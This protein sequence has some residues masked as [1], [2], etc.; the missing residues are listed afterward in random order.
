MPG[1]GRA[2]GLR[3]DRQPRSGDD[4]PVGSDK[5]ASGRRH[6]GSRVHRGHRPVVG[7]HGQVRLQVCQPRGPVE[8]PH[9]PDRLGAYA[10]AAEPGDQDVGGRL[11]VRRS[12]EAGGDDPGAGGLPRPLHEQSPGGGPGQDHPDPRQGPESGQSTARDGLA[13]PA[14]G[15]GMLDDTPIEPGIPVPDGGVPV[16]VSPGSREWLR[17]SPRAGR[18]FWL[19]LAAAGALLV[20]GAYWAGTHATSPAA[21][22]NRYKPAPRTVLTATVVLRR[23]SQTLIVRGV[24][25]AA[26][27]RGVGFG[28]VNVPGAQPIVTAR[29]PRVGSV[30]ADGS[31]LAQVAGR[32]VFAMRGV[33]PMYRDL[34]IGD[35][36]PDV[37]QLQDGLAAVRAFYRN[38]G[39]APPA[40]TSGKGGALVVPQAEIVF[41]PRL[42]A[43]VQ[44]TT[45]ALGQPVGDPA[46]TLA[47]GQLRA[48]VP[49]TAAQVGLV[50]PGH[51]AVLYVTGHGG[52]VRRVAAKVTAIRRAGRAAGKHARS[53]P[54]AVLAPRRPLRWS[55]MGHQVTARIVIAAT[56]GAVLAVPVSALYTTADGETMVTTITH[57]KRINLPVR[58]GAETGG[59]VPVQPLRGQLAAGDRVVVGE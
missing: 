33:T 56:R 25:A 3:V 6:H 35:R 34:T 39:Y 2:A 7:L 9:R 26:S 10:R 41:I 13:S 52:T 32:P 57:G 28:S 27:V 17:S 38:S 23:L 30:V 20:A 18:R 48:V 40:S 46:L 5:S 21:I 49:L 31:V 53:G 47:S 15:S 54:K 51:P 59:Y 24:I 29:P 55:L 50:R 44:S 8:P 58:A 19:A 43:E 14:E 12:R 4:W 45:L 1:S 36:G 11:Q 37:G 16:P 22:E 42:P